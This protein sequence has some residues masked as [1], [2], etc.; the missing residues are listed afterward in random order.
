MRIPFSFF[1][2]LLKNKPFY[3]F[4]MITP[5]DANPNSQLNEAAPSPVGFKNIPAFESPVEFKLE[6][7]IPSWVNGV[8]YRT[9]KTKKAHRY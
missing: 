3:I 2:S 5:A 7:H 1:F 6:G 8:M 4:K 9:G